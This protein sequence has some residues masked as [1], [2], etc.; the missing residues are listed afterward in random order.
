MKNNKQKINQQN[1]R[2]E[3]MN[4]QNQSSISMLKLKD[5]CMVFSLVFMSIAVLLVIYF[6]TIGTIQM[7]LILI[8]SCSTIILSALLISLILALYAVLIKM[9]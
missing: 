4:Q 6:L 7:G 9:K 1:M 3:K 8:T 5:L 2:S